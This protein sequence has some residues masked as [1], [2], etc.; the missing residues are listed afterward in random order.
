MRHVRYLSCLSLYSLGLH[1]ITTNSA[2]QALDRAPNYVNQGPAIAGI[3]KTNIQIWNSQFKK[4]AAQW[5]ADHTDTNVKLLN[6]HSIVA[7]ILD[8][9]TKYGAPDAT[10]YNSTGTSCLWWN[11]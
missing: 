2:F 4:S 10:C 5:A 9:P 8:N 1:S 3:V 6:T 11:K 7:N